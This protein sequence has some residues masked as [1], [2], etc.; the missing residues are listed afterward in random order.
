[1]SAISGVHRG[2][3]DRPV[4][5]VAALIEPLGRFKVLDVRPIVTDEDGP[6]GLDVLE[7]LGG[8]L[9]RGRGVLIQSRRS[10]VEDHQIRVVDHQVGV[11]DLTGGIDLVE[12]HSNGDALVLQ[13]ARQVLGRLPSVLN[14]VV[15][16][17]TQRRAR[18]EEVEPLGFDGDRVAGEVLE[19]QR[20]VTQTAHAGV[21]VVL[22]ALFPIDEVFVSA[23]GRLHER[24]RG[25]LDR[26]IVRR[27]FLGDPRVVAGLHVA[28]EP[29]FTQHVG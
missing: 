9:L 3:Q 20:P 25:L 10:R 12:D 19:G 8:E 29:L 15:A 16:P 7:H 27:Q 26:E 18:R 22:L 21:D 1:M 28:G 4:G 24:G 5:R 23:A 17:G 11:F 13:V 2:A 14:V 6:D